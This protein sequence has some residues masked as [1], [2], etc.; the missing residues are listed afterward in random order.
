[1]ERA[2]AA[3][4]SG[5]VRPHDG[6]RTPPQSDRLEGQPRCDLEVEALTLPTY[7]EFR[8][9]RRR[10][11]LIDLDPVI[12]ERGLHTKT[13][14]PVAYLPA[15]SGISHSLPCPTTDGN[16]HGETD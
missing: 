15:G 13:D 8:P 16:A 11:P 3:E 10:Y 9:D 2:I 7:R 5:K 14:R 4:S 6:E 12:R 1:M